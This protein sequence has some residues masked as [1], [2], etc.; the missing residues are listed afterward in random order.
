MLLSL[1]F[2]KRHRED[3]VRKLRR[4]QAIVH[5][6]ARQ[7]QEQ[8]IVKRERWTE[9]DLDNLPSE[10]PDVFDRKSG[11]LLENEANF[12]NVVAKV[13]SAFANSGG[14]ALILGVQDDGIPDGVPSYKGKTSMKDWIEQKVPNLLDYPL[15]DLRVHTVAKSSPSRIPADREVIVIDVSDSAAAP[16]QSTR[17][18][19]YYHRVGGRSEPARHFYLELLR[20]RLTNPSLSFKLIDAALLTAE[21]YGE[22]IFVV[23]VL[24]IEVTN[25]GRVAAYNWQ[26]NARAS[27]H[28]GVETENLLENFYFSNFPISLPPRVT[29]VRFDR[30]ILPGCEFIEEHTIGLQLRPTDHTIAAVRDDLHRMLKG[31][32][33][34]Y[35]L[36]TE[37]S[38]GEWIPIIL[39]GVTD[40]ETLVAAIRQSCL[41]FFNI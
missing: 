22:G 4:S 8:D 10:E 21:E 12:L 32:Q 17:D 6:L 7:S 1:L 39:T 37:A 24:K 5:A 23:I 30:T 31:L 11:R 26:L 9:A 20:Q 2:Y 13:L 16:H 27:T 28:L 18:H 40:L 14:G 35:R 34:F 3:V 36:A 33:I 15:S 38:P 41:G 25:V 19:I 29:G